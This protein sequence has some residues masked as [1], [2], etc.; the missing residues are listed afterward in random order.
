MTWKAAPASVV[1][2]V[3]SSGIAAVL[4]VIAAWLTKTLIDRLVDQG[5]WS[6]LVWLIAGLALA[7]LTVGI[8]P[9]LG[10]IVQASVDRRLRLAAMDALYLAT[11]RI[12]G[13]G[14]LEDPRFR[15]QLRMAQGA[16]PGALV[17][18]AIGVG[19]AVIT[20]GGFL[21]A[22]VFIDTSLAVLVLAAAAPG[23]LAQLRLNREHVAMLWHL[24][25]TDRRE[26]FYAHLLTSLEAAKEIRL[27]GTGE[28]F[29]RRM[30]SELDTGNRRRAAQDRREGRIH[31]LLVC[32]AACVA[33]AALAWAVWLVTKGRL[34]VG[35]LSVLVASVAGVQSAIQAA[36]NHVGTAHRALVVFQTF[37]DLTA[38]SPDSE[39]ISLAPVPPLAEGIQLTDVWFRYGADEPWILKGLNLTVPSGA[40]VALVGLNGAGKSTLV[41]LL[42]RFHEP[43]LGSICWD[44]RPL[45]ELPVEQLRARIGAVFQDYMTYDLSVLE[46]IGIGDVG[47]LDDSPAIAAAAVRAG[48]HE[49]VGQLKYGYDTLLS[50][51]FLD[52]SADGSRS[53]VLL[54]GGQWQRIALARAFMRDRRDLMILDEP[55]S[56][57]DA[58][59]EYEIHSRLRQQREHSTSLLISHR[60]STVRDADLIVVLDDG[61]VGEQGT[62]DEL[63][64]AGG[65]YADL[66]R[67]QA[68]GYELTDSAGR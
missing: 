50:K 39:P 10:K 40:T 5:H 11:N 35:D 47:R 25:P 24:A 7:G 46:N 33:T 13:L 41:K 51:A 37:L 23:L 42:C 66:F 53:G 27:L 18:D 65:R 20:A 38:V 48:V 52:I 22:L 62:H 32:L 44:G 49:T 29:R 21:A 67:L 9:V 12:T 55:S 17:A 1:C 43:S 58:E 30:L 31:G 61:V 26:M 28:L 59:A 56:G 54:S 6:E 3:V 34:T 8:A 60:L 19:Q 45:Q 64:R 15:D 36:V 4:P 14:R 16:A 63:M 68:S 2:L 57:L